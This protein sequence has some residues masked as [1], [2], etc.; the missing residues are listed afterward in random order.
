MADGI[1]KLV[2]KADD[3]IDLEKHL[4]KK[5]L[6]EEA[7]AFAKKADKVADD[8]V[9]DAAKA[10]KSGSDTKIIAEKNFKDH[11]IRHKSL[12]EKV[13]GKKY[14]KYKTHGQEFLDDIGKI[15]DDGTVEYVG[16][17]T[18]KKGQPAVNIYRGNGITIA[19]IDDG[20]FITILESGK[21]LDL[22]IQIID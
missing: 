13:T 18:L 8:V 1:K 16:K 17:G 7:E 11:F 20:E 5:L 15:I 21:G 4:P 10:I 19:T 9:E 3:A 6:T 14:S 12:L 22:A 2:K